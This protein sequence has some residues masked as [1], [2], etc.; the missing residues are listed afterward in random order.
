MGPE[1]QTRGAAQPPEG[2]RSP[3]KK[4]KLAP[5]PPPA[6]P[7]PGPPGPL[8]KDKNR[9]CW[10]GPPPRPPKPRVFSLLKKINGGGRL[11][12]GKQKWAPKNWVFFPGPPPLWPPPPPTVPPPPPPPGKAKRV[13]THTEISAFFFLPFFPN[14]WLDSIWGPPPHRPPFSPPP[15]TTWGGVCGVRRPPV[16]NFYGKKTL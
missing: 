13:G 14:A 10:G 4:K 15:K 11:G 1:N 16:T 5:P 8:N 12:G 6:V 3:K 2:P 7:A 9:P